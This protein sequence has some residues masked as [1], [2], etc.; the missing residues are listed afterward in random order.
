METKNLPLRSVQQWMQAVIM[1]PDGVNSEES[2]N[3]EMTIDNM[4]LPSRRLTSQQRIEVY[5]NA[6][7]ARLL[8]CMRDEFPAMVALLGEELFNSFAF[9]YLQSHPSASYTLADLGS[10]FHGF[11][12]DNRDSVGDDDD[13]AEPV[14]DHRWFDFML[15]LVLLER[16][17]SEVFSGPGIE[18]IETLN[19]NA[20]SAV[21]PALVGAICLTPAP[22]LRL[23][24]L[25]SRAHEYAIAIRKSG[26]MSAELPKMV[27]TCL[28]VTRI[29]YVVRTIVVEPDEFL[30][31]QK[32]VEGVCL[33]SA[34]VSVVEQSSLS[35]EQL[36]G[37]LADWFTRWAMDR[38]F[39]RFHIP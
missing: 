29:N 2:V 34:I 32:L 26:T 21:A 14:E 38:L 22:C 10:Q 31:L 24:R 16:T 9:S 33:D 35:E 7:Y 12:T 5:S 8:E 4:I 28:V 15:D 17:Y 18:N 23:L 25:K 19:A 37:K 6:Y 13:S 36:A 3:D 1:H 39:V 20:L 30:L 27:E 11:L